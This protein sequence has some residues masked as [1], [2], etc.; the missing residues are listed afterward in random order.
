MTILQM[1]TLQIIAASIG[2]A[3]YLLL[4]VVVIAKGISFK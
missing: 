4:F 1:N 2:F 3:V